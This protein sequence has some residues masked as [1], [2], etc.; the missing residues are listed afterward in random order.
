MKLITAIK[1]ALKIADRIASVNGL[2]C[3]PASQFE[4]FKIKRAWVFGSTIKGK[5]YPNDLD[6]IIDGTLCGRQYVAHKSELSNGVRLG[7]KTDKIFFKNCG[8]RL[9]S[10]STTAVYQ[11]LAKNMKMVRIH[12]WVIDKKYA[13]QRIMIYPKNEFKEWAEDQL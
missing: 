9:P 2:V 5:S 8:V 13:K 6:I 12:E 3:T 1:N 4:C 7:A 10:D 11:F